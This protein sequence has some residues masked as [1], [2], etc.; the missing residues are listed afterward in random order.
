M[1]EIDLR[2]VIGLTLGGIPGVL[3][4][5]FI[6]KSMSVEMLRWLVIFVVLYAAAVMLHAAWLGRKEQRA[7][8]ATAAVAG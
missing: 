2:V 5:A 3:V 1:G 6:V 7:E 8:P 4:A